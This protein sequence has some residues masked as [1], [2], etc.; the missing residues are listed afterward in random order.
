[1]KSLV[2]T[3]I[4][5]SSIGSG[6]HMS[7]LIERFVLPHG[8]KW[9]ARRQ[10]N[11]FTIGCIHSATPEQGSF[12]WFDWDQKGLFEATRQNEIVEPRYRKH[13]SYRTCTRYIELYIPYWKT[14][15]GFLSVF[16]NCNLKE[17]KPDPLDPMPK[18]PIFPPPENHTTIHQ[19]RFLQKF[20]WEGCPNP[21]FSHQTFD[22]LISNLQIEEIQ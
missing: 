12:I 3:A 1:M 14:F 7:H 6:V 10:C 16:D 22:A 20:L 5:I 4:K 21:D 19:Q 11:T 15:T 2:Q 8:S 18:H 17:K 9:V 13:A